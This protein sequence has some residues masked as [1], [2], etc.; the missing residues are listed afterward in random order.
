MKNLTLLLIVLLAINFSSCKKAKKADDLVE[1]SNPAT[2]KKDVLVDVSNNVVYATY[3]DM[4]SKSNA[5]HASLIAF[6]NTQI[7]RAHV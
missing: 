3:V 5:L 7:G 1:P 4:A 6:A 2:I